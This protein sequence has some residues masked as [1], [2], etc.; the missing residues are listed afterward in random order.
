MPYLHFETLRGYQEMAHHI[1]ATRDLLPI[2]IERSRRAQRKSKHGRPTKTQE[3][4]RQNKI[5]DADDPLT[6]NPYEPVERKA[7]KWTNILNRTGFSLT[8]QDLK[9]NMSSKPADLPKFLGI[10]STDENGAEGMDLE[11]GTVKNTGSAINSHSNSTPHEN[12]ANQFDS[13]GM[14][15]TATKRENGVE[16]Q[17]VEKS[18][19][20]E[21]GIEDSQEDT[22]PKGSKP[23]LL[24]MSNIVPDEANSNANEQAKAPDTTSQVN[25]PSSHAGMNK[26]NPEAP[27]EVTKNDRPE[28]VA[29]T[30]GAMEQGPQ[31]KQNFRPPLR[32]STFKGKD[33]LDDIPEGSQSRTEDPSRGGG[34][35]SEQPLR[36][37]PQ[38]PR[39]PL[40]QLDEILMKAYSLPNNLGQ[41]PPLQLRR[42]LDQYFYTDLLSTYERDN[43]Q[44]VLR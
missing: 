43:D 29:N 21:I 11:K 41:V 5:L 8:F 2:R 25:L 33:R 27:K 7:S 3:K 12:K 15:M 10:S 20:A 40:G 42:T 44:V 22:N 39:I 13:T 26:S 17:K 19:G 30:I 28:V 9:A 1:S 16:A 23:N 6:E 18:P 38:K 35:T 36:S 34:P 31:N 32:V 14:E 37:E 4:A 24:A